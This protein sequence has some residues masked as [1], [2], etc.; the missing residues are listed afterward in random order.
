MPHCFTI[1][2]NGRPVSVC[3]SRQVPNPEYFHSRQEA[4]RAALQRHVGAIR[5]S[6]RE[7]ISEL[8]SDPAVDP[9]RLAGV[10]LDLGDLNFLLQDTLRARSHYSRA[11]EILVAGGVAEEV[12]AELMDRP[13]EISKRL[14]GMPAMRLLPGDRPPSGLV[15]FEVSEEGTIRNLGITGS[16]ADLDQANQQRIIERLRHSVYRPRLE[17][18]E[19]VAA[20]V[21]GLAAAQL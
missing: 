14:L 21:D 12:R 13:R 10:V 19:P 15:S 8:E 6:L 1:N 16:G 3:E 5:R 17:A 11:H 20:R 9:L 4:K 18:G 7:L 2:E